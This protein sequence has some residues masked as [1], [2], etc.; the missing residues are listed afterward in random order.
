MIEIIFSIAVLIFSVVVHEV[1]HGVAANLLGDPTAKYQGRL[2][3]NPIPHL[4]LF[5]SILLP[6]F[7]V[8][9]NSP[10]FFAYAKP[11][12]YNPYNLRNQRWG[13][14]IVGLAGPGANIL[15]AL[16]FALVMNAGFFPSASSLIF[17]VIIQIN[18]W[19]ALF[20]LI[21]VPP[22]DGS[23]LLFSL[24]PP[25][26]YNLEAMLERYGFFILIVLLFVLPGLILAPL[27]N[28]ATIIVR[29]LAGA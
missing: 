16:I 29:L 12:P 15:T 5:G 13:P 18:I 26:F 28:F 6:L 21:P 3:L 11:V 17:L 7:F 14:A 4:D 27:F 8:L 23:K 19:L 10:I 2:T 1:S 24:L 9:V 20:N 22:L 25:R